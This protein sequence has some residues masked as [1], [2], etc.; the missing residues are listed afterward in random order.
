MLETQVPIA[1]ISAAKTT[2]PVF[3]MLLAFDYVMRACDMGVKNLAK[4]P[5]AQESTHAQVWPAE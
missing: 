1:G 4:S 2:P 5:W 3:Y